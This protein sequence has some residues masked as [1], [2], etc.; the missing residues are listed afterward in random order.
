MHKNEFQAGIMKAHEEI[1]IA[2]KDKEQEELKQTTDIKI[3]VRKRPILSHELEKD[4]FDVI[5]LN[6]ASQGDTV[7]I[8]E[9]KMHRDMKKKFITLY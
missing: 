9:C 8:H 4:E 7:I 1:S 2:I 6:H 3:Y 5:T